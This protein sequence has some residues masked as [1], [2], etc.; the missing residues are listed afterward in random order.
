[1]FTVRSW[2]NLFSKHVLC[3]PSI[4]SL[5]IKCSIKLSMVNKQIII[6]DESITRLKI[7][8]KILSQGWR[9]SG[10]DLTVSDVEGKREESQRVCLEV[11]PLRQIPTHTR[12]VLIVMNCFC[13]WPTSAGWGCN[14][15][16]HGKGCPASP[17][18]RPPPNRWQQRRK[19]QLCSNPEE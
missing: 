8:K 15:R 5:C 9:V 17:R 13:S 19:G 3:F 1:M 14:F 4:R 2:H 7:I 10:G 6:A 12:L 18:F 11:I 16:Q